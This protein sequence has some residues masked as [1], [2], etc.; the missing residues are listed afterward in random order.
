[1]LSDEA[2]IDQIKSRPLNNSRDLALAL[3]KT[4]VSGAFDLEKL[5]SALSAYFGMSQKDPH[6]SVYVSLEEPRFKTSFKSRHYAEPSEHAGFNYDDLYRASTVYK[7]KI[8]RGWSSNRFGDWESN[9]GPITIGKLEVRS[10]LKEWINADIVNES[11]KFRIYSPNGILRPCIIKINVSYGDNQE[12]IK[13]EFELKRSDFV[14]A[15]FFRWK[16]RIELPE[17]PT[18]MFLRDWAVERYKPVKS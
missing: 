7:A 12:D 3:L 11:L 14:P 16:D 1:M 5:Q 9:A 10:R 6:T 4:P 2:V 8:K 17:L 15:S 13:E 18:E